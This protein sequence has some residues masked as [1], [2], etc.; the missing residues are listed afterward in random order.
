MTNQEQQPHSVTQ[1]VTKVASGIVAS[2][3]GSPLT[4]AL[5]LVN[6][7][8]LGVGAYVL[9]EVA[10]TSRE[11][12]KTQTELILTL[13]KDIRDCRQPKQGTPTSYDRA[14]DEPVKL[15]LVPPPDG[16]VP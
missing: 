10:E 14:D 4:L 2:F 8:F 6:L 5:L 7:V 11:R 9:G 16:T 3:G 12:N 15:P 1:G 13:V